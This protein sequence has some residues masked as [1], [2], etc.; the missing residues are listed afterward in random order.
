[1]LTRWSSK[2]SRG[3]PLSQTAGGNENV[4]LVLT[5]DYRAALAERREH[6]EILAVAIRKALSSKE[7]L[8]LFSRMYARKLQSVWHQVDRLMQTMQLG[9][10]LVEP[11]RFGGVGWDSRDREAQRLESWGSRSGSSFHQAP[12]YLHTPTTHLNNTDAITRHTAT[13]ARLSESQKHLEH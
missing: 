6:A 5:C 12:I 2:R 3:Q 11:Q 4:F 10:T 9:R 1:M 13:L 7:E 8:W